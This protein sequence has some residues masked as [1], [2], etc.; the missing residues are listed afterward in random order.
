M[1]IIREIENPEIPL[2]AD[3]LYLA[4]FQPPGDEILPKETIYNPN[5]HIYINDFD[6]TDDCA[7]VAEQDDVVV[8]AAWT[9][10]IPGYGHIDNETPELAISVLPEYKGRGIGTSLLNRLFELLRERGYRRT[11]LSVQKANPAA[12]LYRRLGYEIIHENSEDF[13]MLKI[14]NV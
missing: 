2:L 10:I 4:I 3:F 11:S 5:I 14:L 6:K 13:T 9:R 8:G 7:V 1:I 12:R